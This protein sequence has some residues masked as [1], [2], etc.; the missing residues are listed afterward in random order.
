MEELDVIWKKYNEYANKMAV[1]LGRTSNI[2]G[3]FAEYIVCQYYSGE[4]F[5]ASNASA[6]IKSK[7]GKLIQVKSRKHNKSNGTQLSVIRS[8][9]FDFLIV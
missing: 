3:E 5:E 1:I 2:V 7:D 4:L 8:W 9:D 6:D